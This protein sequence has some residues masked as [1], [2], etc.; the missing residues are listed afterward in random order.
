MEYVLTFGNTNHS[1]KGEQT[2]LARQIDVAVMPLPPAIR[3]GCGLCLRIWADD[4]PAAR[5]ALDQAGVPI[6]DI[7]ARRQT[8]DGSAYTLYSGGEDR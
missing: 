4:L 8:D 1:I 3:A 2:L 5:E 6:Q 7:Y